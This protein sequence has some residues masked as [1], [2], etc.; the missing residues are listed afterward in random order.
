MEWDSDIGEASEPGTGRALLILASLAVLTSAA[1]LLVGDVRTHLVGYVLA[2]LV[3]FTCVAL[4]RRRALDRLLA[5]GVVTSTKL[6][7]FALGVLFAGLACSVVH[8]WFV[9]RHW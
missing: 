5:M 3:A 6:N 4:F 9:A 7:S 2:S 8:A 1:M